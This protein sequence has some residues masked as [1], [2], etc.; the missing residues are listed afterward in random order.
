VRRAAVAVVVAAACSGTAT[1]R[2]SSDENN[3]Y[4]LEQALARRQLPPAPA[5]VNAAHQ[6]RVFALTAGA[7]ANKTIVAYDLA[8]DKLLWKADA[9]VQSRIA[10]GGDFVVA[11]EGKQ[12][13]ARDQARGQP[14]WR[15]ALRGTFVGAACD[16]D[17]AYLV[18]K[19]GGAAMLAGYDG[20]SGRELWTSRADGQLGAPAAQG[21]LVYV[22]YLSQ[23]LAIVDGATGE[24][25]TRIRNLDEQISVLRVTSRAAYYGSKQGVYEL[26]ARSASGKRAGS[27]YGAVVIPPQLDRTS[28]ARDAYDPVQAGYSAF[29]R[30]RV[31]WTTLGD[32]YVIH[33]FRFVLGFGAN[34]ELRWAY[35]HPRVELVAADHTGAVI[36]GVSTA[37]EIVA[38]DPQ[39][40]AVR[41]RA[42]LGTSSPVLGATFD[43][44]G[45]S[46]ASPSEPVDTV[47][48]L[49]SI[50]RD[51]DAR[52]DRVKE[53]AVGALAKLP[54]AEVTADL[55]DVLADS[56]APQRLKD[57]VV[58]LL[59]QRRDP[60]SLPVLTKQLGVH[61][62][63]LAQTEPDALGPVAKAIAGLGGVALDPVQV[64][65]ALAALQFHLDAPTTAS[66][67]LV[68]VI[69]AMTA[70]G[71]GSE[72]AALDS[73]LLL[74]H[75]DDALGS[76]AAWQKAIVVALATKGGPAE[77]EL[78]R[79]IAADPRTVPGL[80]ATI[81][82]A[83]AGD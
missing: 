11:V 65:A 35:S 3:R 52:F 77:R 34:G 79:W 82:E 60:A 31:L 10:V 54:G 59:V 41:A 61:T 70:I 2:L 28:Y 5:P 51:H 8:T 29:D 1:F 49:V 50:A 42:S 63:F 76:D 75:A 7:G 57:T 66:S 27:T 58:D 36:A 24:Q 9:D 78:L 68:H 81:R 83:T 19:D 44:D 39:T 38:V 30:A 47:K 13:V 40:G 4:A 45:W 48:A 12:L 20:A 64:A 25:L 14:R 16:R 37:G 53:L 26:D 46:P 80:T 74:Y 72:R 22:P 21:G 6:P 18:T 15:V 43:A 33:Y 62:D 32:G 17:R 23:W 55:L 71:G 73:H 69:A 56:R 67:D